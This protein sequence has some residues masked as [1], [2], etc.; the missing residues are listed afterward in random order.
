MNPENCVS[1]CG[2]YDDGSCGADGG[3][4]VPDAASKRP[5]LAGFDGLPGGPGCP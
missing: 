1:S 2:C 4:D 3:G 5:S